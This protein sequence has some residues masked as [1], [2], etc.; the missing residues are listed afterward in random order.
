MHLGPDFVFG[1]LTDLN[2]NILHS[3]YYNFTYRDMDRVI[4]RVCATIQELHARAVANDTELIGIAVA[5]PGII[6]SDNGIS[7]FLPHYVEW[8]TRVPIGKLLQDRLGLDVPICFE[9]VNRLQAFAEFVRGKGVGVQSLVTVDAICEG[10][11]AGILIKGGMHQGSEWLSGEIG[12]MVLQPDDGP[13]CICGGKGCFEALVST[14]RIMQKLRDRRAGSPDSLVYKNGI[15]GEA[16][17]ENLF[18]AYREGDSLAAEIIEDVVKWFAI[19]LNN[20][21]MVYD[22]EMII[23]QGIYSDAGPHFL[24]ALRKKI[25]QMSLPYV[26]R[27]VEI[28]FSDFGRERGVI[29]AASYLLSHYFESEVAR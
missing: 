12:H 9:N 7:V 24:E 26:N 21:I 15:E 4:G 1:A 20:V 10:L 6:D 3:A 22:P 29:G 28:V 13:D 16:D 11:G 5:L 19:G 25:D 14:K 2:G 27:S 18:S 23:L 17:L 8:G